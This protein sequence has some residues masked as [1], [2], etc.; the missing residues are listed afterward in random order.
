[1]GMSLITPAAGLAALESVLLHHCG[2]CGLT[3]APAVASA[4]PFLWPQFL[5]RQAQRGLGISFLDE[6]S[7]PATAA[8]ASAAALG[9]PA[10]EQRGMSAAAVM[11]LVHSCVQEVLG[12]AVGEDEPLM[13]AGLDS[14]GSVELRNSLESRLGMRLPPTLVSATDSEA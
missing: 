9:T 14:L 11:S 3:A 13:A 1:M 6:F 4:V 12:A 8:P 10:S 7:E 5:R 2:T